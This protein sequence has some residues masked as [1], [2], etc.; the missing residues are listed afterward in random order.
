MRRMWPPIARVVVDAWAGRYS[1][2]LPQ[3][4]NAG[5]DS[6]CHRA[7]R[8]PAT[9]RRRSSA[10]DSSACS[11]RRR[12]GRVGGPCREAP[13]ARMA[14][15]VDDDRST[16]PGPSNGR[17]PALVERERERSRQN[18]M[19][20]AGSDGSG[21]NANRMRIQVSRARQ[22]PARRVPGH[23]QR[24]RV[25]V[26]GVV[27]RRARRPA[28]SGVPAGCAD[29]GTIDAVRC[30]ARRSCAGPMPE[31]ISSFRASRARAGGE[32]HLAT[33]REPAVQ[34]RRRPP[35]PRAR[36]RSRAAA[37]APSNSSPRP[38]H[39]SR[40]TGWR[41]CAPDRGGRAAPAPAVALR[42]ACGGR[43]RHAVVVQVERRRTP[44]HDLEEHRPERMRGWRCT[45][46]WF[47][48]AAQLSGRRLPR[49]RGAGSRAAPRRTTSRHCRARPS[50]RSP[51]R[52]PRAAH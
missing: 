24:R 46:A 45:S 9:R 3:G 4:A 15:G 12:R 27:H 20:R 19:V 35:C 49:P 29:R 10:S 52:A 33:W 6:N 11:I 26:V 7:M 30:R 44:R 42:H 23:P 28:S 14:G 25:L 39:Q 13:R 41:G 34:R 17:I 22:Q 47:I 37:S 32:H 48:L 2:A 18:C 36:L 38:S 51:R 21:R 8:Q 5:A 43:S 31:S 1:R 16:P 50:R 40:C